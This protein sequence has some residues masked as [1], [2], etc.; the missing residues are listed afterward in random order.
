M[1]LGKSVERSGRWGFREI[2]GMRVL[3][4]GLCSD[5]C[6]LYEV[7]SPFGKCGDEVYRGARSGMGWKERWCDTKSDG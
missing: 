7:V 3:D 5:K 6:K 4:V 1:E 2:V